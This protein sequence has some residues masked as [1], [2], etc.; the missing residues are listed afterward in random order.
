MVAARAATKSSVRRSSD[1]PGIACGISVPK[2]L[3]ADGFEFEFTKID[4]ALCDLY[5]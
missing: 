3:L 1:S 5:G 4:A 2:R